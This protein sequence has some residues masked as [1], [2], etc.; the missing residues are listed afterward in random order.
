MLPCSSWLGAGS[1]GAGELGLWR[2]LPLKEQTWSRGKRGSDGLGRK[3]A[4]AEAWS[5]WQ[6][7]AVGDSPW[8]CNDWE[9]TG[10]QEGRDG[11]TRERGRRDGDVRGQRGGGSQTLH[12][13][14]DQML[15]ISGN[16]NRQEPQGGS[17]P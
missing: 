13:T 7:H 15:V 11:R 10:S 9:G 5:C 14:L 12:F 2:S 17:P 8:R 16:V 6:V 4:A 1:D 3:E